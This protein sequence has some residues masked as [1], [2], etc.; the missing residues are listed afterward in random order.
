MSCVT[1]YCNGCVYLG[2]LT[3]GKYCAYCD[4]TSRSRGCPAGDGCDKKIIGNR[5]YSTKVYTAKTVKKPKETHKVV[6]TDELALYEKESNRKREMAARNRALL[7]GRQKAA[8]T[9]FR[10]SK[11][12]TVT[13]MAKQLGTKESTFRKWITEYT[14]ANWDVLAKVGLSKPDGLP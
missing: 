13:E 11:G 4:V 14:K 6:T 2:K 12:W 5:R 3:G 1:K 7:Q 9:E 8:I 10:E